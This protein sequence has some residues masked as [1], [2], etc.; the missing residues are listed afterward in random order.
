MKSRLILQVH[1]ELI[2]DVHESELEEVKDI[3]VRNMED[4]TALIVPLKVDMKI[5]ESWYETK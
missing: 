3:L 5:G 4:A 2:I 1:D